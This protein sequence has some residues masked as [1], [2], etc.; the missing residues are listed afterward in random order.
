MNRILTLTKTMLK[1]TTYDFTQQLST[2]KK[3]N[4]KFMI[5]LFAFLFIYL[6]GIVFYLWNTLIKSAVSLGQPGIAIHTLFASASV[7][8]LIIGILIVPGIFYFSKDIERYLVLPVKASDILFSKFI[9][10]LV[11][12]YVSAAVIFIP[13]ALAYIVNIKPDLFFI[14]RFILSSLM[15]PIIPFTLSL[16]FMILILTFIPFFKNKDVYT[17]VS[18]FLGVVLGL[19]MAYLGQTSGTGGADFLANIMASIASGDNALLKV[20][21]GVFPTIPLLSQG[22]VYADYGKMILGIVVSILSPF[23]LVTLVQKL[24][25]KGVIGIDEASSKKTVLTSEA[26]QKSTKQRSALRSI[27]RYDIRNILRTPTFTTNYFAGL[28]I[29]PVSFV[30]PLIIGI[31]KSPVSITEINQ[32]LQEIMNTNFYSQAFYVKFALVSIIGLLISYFMANVGMITATS[33]SRE[34]RTL[35]QFRA[36]P[37]D[38][39]TLIHAKIL[40][41]SIIT[42]IPTWIIGI[43]V[44][45]FLKLNIGYICLFIISSFL[46]SILSNTS[47]IV[48]DVLSPKLIWD[49]ETQAIKQN[50]LAAVP[51]FSSFLIIGG[52]V[53]ASLKYN[54]IHVIYVFGVLL[55]ILSVLVYQLIKKLVH[56]RLPQIIETL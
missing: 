33:I 35:Q 15:I 46:G 20:L 11:T 24:Y 30:I 21:N 42:V 53:F 14:I 2:K 31:S 32:T 9:T 34:G 6:G 3:K 18:T 39:M 29:I 22:V 8:I 44:A 54:P 25:F 23:L 19:G 16:V 41:G 48:L 43:L 17:Y 51:L 55:M 47:A 38:F 36:M 49:N 27:M 52:F 56:K 1:T 12:M 5:L 10:S 50:F 26:F 40:I 4:S 45:S 37:L 28:I 7:Y 13:F